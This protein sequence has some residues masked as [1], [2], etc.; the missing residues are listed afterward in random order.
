[1]FLHLF[2]V[3]EERLYR[4]KVTMRHVCI[5]TIAVRSRNISYSE[6]VFLT[7]LYPAC[8]ELARYCI[9]ICGLYDCTISLYEAYSESKYRFTEKKIRVRFRTKFYCYQILHSSKYLQTYS[10]PLL[11]TYR[12]RA[13]V[14]YTLLTGG[15]RLRCWPLLHCI[16]QI[17]VIKSLAAQEL[18]QL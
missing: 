4:Y 7:L 15:G 5:T 1:M 6:R 3:R 10:L 17:V 16:F 9:V 8:K 13:Q 11:S 12:S 18:L 2:D 14:L